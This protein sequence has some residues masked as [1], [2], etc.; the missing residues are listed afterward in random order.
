MGLTEMR[1]VAA[2]FIVILRPEV[3]AAHGL[4]PRI[5]NDVETKFRV[6]VGQKQFKLVCPVIAPEKDSLMIQWVKNGENLDWESR[7]KIGKDGKELKMKS[8]RLEDSGRYQCQATNGFGYKTVDLIVHVFDPNNNDSS[9]KNFLVLSNSTASPSWLIDMHSEWSMPIQVNN[10]GKLELRCPAKANPFPDIR[11]YQNDILLSTNSP[12]HIAS[13]SIDPA[14]R[15]HSGNYRCVVE[16][17]LGSLDFLFE[18][19]VDDYFDASTT[20]SPIQDDKLEPIIE[21]PYNISVY[22]GHTAQFQCKAQSSQSLLIKWLK[23]ISDPNEV[24]KNDPNAT[25]ISAN[26]MHLL[27]LEHIQSES[28]V[29][30]NDVNMYLNRLTIPQVKLEHAGKYLCVVTNAEGKISYKAAELRVLPAYDVTIH[31]SADKFLII[32]IPIVLVFLLIVVL[33]VVYLKR[34]QEPSNKTNTINKPPPPP[35]IPPPAAPADIEWQPERHPTRSYPEFSIDSKKPLLL[36]NAM[37]QQNSGRYFSGAATVDRKGLHRSGRVTGFDEQSNAYDCG[38]P[39]P[40]WTQAKPSVHNSSAYTAGYRT[41]EGN[42]NHSR[43]YPTVVTDDYSD[44]EQ[45]FFFHRR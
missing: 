5:Q 19:T 40:Y 26:G 30:N 3:E 44:Q 29:A 11:W 21:Q 20:E 14:D 22:A 13:L 45:P 10:G 34:S 7:Y 1:L 2:I 41:L 37:F 24:R 42:F 33:A 18:V 8:V 35:R 27:V 9:V 32:L 23:S 16:N 15:S 17:A 38:S 31:L 28:L 12:K 4:P 6:P 25:V 43:H 36:N 39:Q